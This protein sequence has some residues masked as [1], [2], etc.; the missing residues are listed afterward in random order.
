MKFF[1]LNSSGNVGKSLIS[2]ELL[3]PRLEDSLIIEVETVNRGSKEMSHLNVEQFKSGDDFMNLYLKLMEIENVI[4]D[5]GAS[6]LAVFWEQMSEYAG[7]ESLF[8][9]FIIPTVPGD[10]EM[11][12]TYKTI[13]FL[14]S[15]GIND[16]K[17]KVI[18]NRIKNTVENDFSVLLSADFDF[19]TTLAIKESSLFKDLGFMK[20]TIA[21]IYNPNL[22]YYKS[23][24]LSAK[25]PKEKLLLVKKDL[26]NRMAVKTKED[27]DYIFSSISG[28]ELFLE[29]IEEKKDKDKERYVN[30]ENE[31]ESE[32]N[33]DDEEL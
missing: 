17:I 1:V 5:V 32:I 6:N 3:Y 27:L 2:R 18:F 21:D 22:D 30:E 11:T 31:L 28:L 29:P 23:Q 25:E 12:D 7:I 14:R 33:D 20:Q 15:Q 10:K 4:V 24:I 16:S 8:D 26:A 19:D 9:L 13:L